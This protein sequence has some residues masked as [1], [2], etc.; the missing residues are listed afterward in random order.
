VDDRRLIA[1]V[2]AGDRVAGRELYDAHVQRVYRLVYRLVGGHEDL[3]QEFT[4]EAFIRAFDRLAYFRGEAALGTW[5]HSIA[6]SVTLNGLRRQNRFHRRETQLDDAPDSAI[7]A[8]GSADPDLRDRI[9]HAIESLREI[10]RVVV[11]M[12]DV[13]GYTHAEIGQ[14]LGVPEGTSKARLS[15]ARAKLRLALA[16]D[17]KE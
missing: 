4:Q 16:D 8:P 1:R 6:V 10:Y 5:L 7:T 3:A 2:L 13:E 12:H 15:V 11:I 14:I 17:A 9:R